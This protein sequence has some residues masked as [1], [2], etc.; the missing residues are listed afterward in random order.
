MAPYSQS[1]LTERGQI[2]LE[3]LF[4]LGFLIL[5]I[6]ALQKEWERRSFKETLEGQRIYK[7]KIYQ[8]EL[9]K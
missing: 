9:T 6:T 2:L 5:I 3:C 4:A 7:F 8:P 1:P